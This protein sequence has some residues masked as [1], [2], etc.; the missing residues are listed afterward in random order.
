MLAVIFLLNISHAGG[1]P[2]K[3]IY[4]ERE[5]RVYIH[6]RLTDRQ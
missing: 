3:W 5:A 1:M 6:L 2:L 4:Q